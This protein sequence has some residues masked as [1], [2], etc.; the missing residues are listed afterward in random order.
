VLQ[1]QMKKLSKNLRKLS[2][3]PSL[4][5]HCRDA[6]KFI[7]KTSKKACQIK[8]DYLPLSGV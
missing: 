8:K 5:E 7:Q 2:A 3:V 6:A 4:L 1:R